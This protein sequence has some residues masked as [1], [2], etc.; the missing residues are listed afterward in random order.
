MNFQSG[1]ALLEALEFLNDISYPIY[2]PE[3]TSFYFYHCSSFSS[4]IYFLVY[5]VLIPYMNGWIFAMAL[6]FF[7]FL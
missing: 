4:L 7:L 1:S 3:L 5:A 6:I 2:I